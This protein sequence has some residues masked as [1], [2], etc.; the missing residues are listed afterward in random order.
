MTWGNNR[1][2]FI[3]HCAVEKR[4]CSGLR[5]VWEST[6]TKAAESNLKAGY[7]KFEQVSEAIRK[8]HSETYMSP[9]T[10]SD[11]IFANRVVSGKSAGA[12]SARIP[13][14]DGADDRF[15]AADFGRVGRPV[16]VNDVD[17][18]PVTKQQGR[19]AARR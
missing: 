16:V 13:C 1:I 3:N 6:P 7:E 18:Q 14:S 10:P 2:F 15:A 17:N 5:T 4:D 8:T 19:Q 12:D 11:P 9:S